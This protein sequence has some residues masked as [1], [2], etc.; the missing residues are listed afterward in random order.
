MFS[1][2]DHLGARG[3][4]CTP[5]AFM[6]IGQPGVEDLRRRFAYLQATF[7]IPDPPPGTVDQR[8]PEAAPPG[9]SARDVLERGR[10]RDR[11]FKEGATSGLGLLR[12]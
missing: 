8:H 1:A 7:G 10:V 11:S 9:S 3:E 2:T 6:R 4:A 12:S 5:A